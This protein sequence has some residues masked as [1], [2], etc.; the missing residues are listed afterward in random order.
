M[1]LLYNG[2]ANL[3]L[4]G[5]FSGK[6]KAFP[7]PIEKRES[8]PQQAEFSDPIEIINQIDRTSREAANTRR[9]SWTAPWCFSAH[10]HTPQKAAVRLSPSGVSA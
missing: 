4:K 6:G 9:A 5:P 7:K 2:S 3:S 8:A 10:S 1:A